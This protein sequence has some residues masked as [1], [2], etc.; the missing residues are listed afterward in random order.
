[1]KIEIIDPHFLKIV[2]YLKTRIKTT[3]DCLQLFKIPNYLIN[4]NLIKKQK[5]HFFEYFFCHLNSMLKSLSKNS[6]RRMFL[7]RFY[8]ICEYLDLA[9]KEFMEENGLRFSL[10]LVLE[11]FTSQ[12]ETQKKLVIEVPL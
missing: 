5:A 6:T 3:D 12:F 1:M 10:K 7:C 8:I 4:G 2:D 9:N 11:K